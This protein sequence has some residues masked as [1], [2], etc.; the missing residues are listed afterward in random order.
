MDPV[1]D[2]ILPQ[3]FLGYSWES[4]PGPLGWQS[5]VLTTIPNRW[6][7]DIII[8][9]IIVII[10]ITIILTSQIRELKAS[11]TIQP[12]FTNL[13]TKFCTMHKNNSRNPVQK[14]LMQ[15][16]DQLLFSLLSLLK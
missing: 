6:S 4:N 16:N 5:D 13:G 8:I 7:D 15:Q 11:S 2:P 12:D 1:P 9:I 14:Y 10:I 3:K